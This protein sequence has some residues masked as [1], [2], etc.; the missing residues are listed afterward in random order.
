[1]EG[2][3]REG[4]LLGLSRA[5]PTGTGL[6]TEEQTGIGRLGVRHTTGRCALTSVLIGGARVLDTAGEQR[7]WMRPLCI[8]DAMA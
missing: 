4:A 8:E 6:A 2:K 1:M 5:V 7:I 3:T